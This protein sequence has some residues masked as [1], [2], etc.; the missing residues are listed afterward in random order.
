MIV[1]SLTSQTLAYN[2]N[3]SM[4]DPKELDI[5]SRSN[6]KMQIRADSAGK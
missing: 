2:I 1:T 5:V 6:A 3:A 4:T